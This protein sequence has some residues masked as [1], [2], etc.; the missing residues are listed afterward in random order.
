MLFSSSSLEKKNI[1]RRVK[2]FF[3]FQFLTCLFHSEY[4]TISTTEWMIDGFRFVYVIRQVSLL[5]LPLIPWLK[6]AGSCSMRE[7][8]MLHHTHGICRSHSF[9]ACIHIYYGERETGKINHTTKNAFE[10]RCFYYVVKWT[11]AVYT[12]NG[13]ECRKFEVNQLYL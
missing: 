5:A 7:H 2:T 4:R 10:I 1:A 8:F 11:Y 12:Q 9:I 13:K 6:W 3:F